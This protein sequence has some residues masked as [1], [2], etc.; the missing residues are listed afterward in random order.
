MYPP[1]QAADI[2]IIAHHCTRIVAITDSG[3]ISYQPRQAAALFALG[4]TFA[5]AP[6]QANETA[7]VTD[8]PASVSTGQVEDAHRWGD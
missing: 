6:V 7:M 4:L 8:A 1:R 3:S 2:P 5:Q